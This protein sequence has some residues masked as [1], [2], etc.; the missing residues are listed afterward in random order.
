MTGMNIRT[1]SRRDY[2]HDSIGITRVSVTCATVIYTEKSNG[3]VVAKKLY[4]SFIQ[5]IS[6]F[7]VFDTCINL[8]DLV[9]KEEYQCKN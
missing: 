4:C 7:L 1:K 5:V 2:Y 3:G 6:L 8:A 9:P